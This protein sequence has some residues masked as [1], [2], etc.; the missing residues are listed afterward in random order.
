MAIS[1]C[2][3]ERAILATLESLL[4]YGAGKPITPEGVKKFAFGGLK[5]EFTVSLGWAGN[6]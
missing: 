5:L 2:Q 6:Q 1:A 3:N 4:R